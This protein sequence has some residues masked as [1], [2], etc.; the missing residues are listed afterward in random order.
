MKET[1]D[2]AGLS[3]VEKELLSLRYAITDVSTGP[4]GGVCGHLH[5]GGPVF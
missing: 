3:D 2:L 1:K 4:R 5:Q